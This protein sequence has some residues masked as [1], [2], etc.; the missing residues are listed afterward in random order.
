[1]AHISAGGLFTN[2]SLAQLVTLDR[3]SFHFP[4]AAR[5]IKAIFFINLTSQTGEQVARVQA[6]F[7]GSSIARPALG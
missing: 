2:L 4:A 6:S 1:M 3:G 7:F 5:L